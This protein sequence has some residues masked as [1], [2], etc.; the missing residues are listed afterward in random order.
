VIHSIRTTKPSAPKRIATSKSKKIKEKA[1]QLEAGSAMTKFHMPEL[2]NINLVTAPNMSRRI[3]DLTFY[4]FPNFNKCDALLYFPSTM[5]RHLN[6]GDFPSLLELLNT[7]LHK[8]CSVH[9]L[10]GRTTSLNPGQF[11]NLFELANEFYP[12]SVMCMHS[13]KVVDNEIR[14]KLYFKFTDNKAIYES[15]IRRI[16]GTAFAP[17]FLPIRSLQMKEAFNVHNMSEEGMSSL[18]T[19]LDSD[20]DVVVYGSVDLHLSFDETTKRVMDVK[21]ISELSSVVNASSTQPGL[22]PFLV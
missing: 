11:V 22:E 10:S 12:D 20:C 7:H 8:N 5:A 6:T 18:C 13:T 16:T 3:K 4:S 14:A 1:D 21:F 19:L 2:D 9:L 17:H 15:L